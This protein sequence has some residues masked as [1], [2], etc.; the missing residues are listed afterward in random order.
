ML[1]KPEDPGTRLV[2]PN[3]IPE[4][5]PIHPCQGRATLSHPNMFCHSNDQNEFVCELKSD[6]LAHRS[7]PDFD[8][9]KISQSQ[10]RM[11]KKKKR[12]NRDF[13]TKAK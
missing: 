9:V 3:S 7:C 11:K 12:M 13:L 10:I 6:L 4:Q 8:S 2:H 1:L 5:P